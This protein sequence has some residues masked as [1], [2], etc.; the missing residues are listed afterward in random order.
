MLLSDRLGVATTLFC[1]TC[2][3]GKLNKKIVGDITTTD[4]VV[5]FMLLILLLMSVCVTVTNSPV[6]ET[7]TY[8]FC[9]VF[10]PL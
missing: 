2:N 4:T 10:V 3:T 1:C 7:L 6:G 9:G 5:V 8:R